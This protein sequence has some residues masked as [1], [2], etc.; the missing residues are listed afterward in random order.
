MVAKGRHYYSGG[1][2]QDDDSGV[3]DDTVVPAS[4]PRHGQGGG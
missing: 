4:R 3:V 1:D 2:W